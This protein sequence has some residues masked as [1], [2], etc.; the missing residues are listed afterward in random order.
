MPQNDHQH[1][2]R[3]LEEDG[4]TP[5]PRAEYVEL[6]VTTC[7]S[8]L[9]GASD[10]VDLVKTAWAQ[11]YDALGCADLN[12]MAGVVRLHAEAIKAQIRPVI[13]TR[14]KLVTGEEFLAYPRNRAAYGRLCSLLSKGK[15]HDLGGQWQSKGVCDIS[16]QDLSEYSQDVQLIA[17]P[18]EDI[19]RFQAALRN[20]S[21]R[22]PGLK[23]I[24]AS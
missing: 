4:F 18:G 5:N 11:G 3:R 19:C 16:L 2:R 8:F 24:A 1:L 15:M 17:L 14:L 10:A 23:Y 9:H 21:G 6:G 12:T 7:F 22:L 20:W 13:G